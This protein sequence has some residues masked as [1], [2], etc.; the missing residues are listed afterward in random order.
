MDSVFH[1]RQ[2]RRRDETPAG[3]SCLYSLSKKPL[4]F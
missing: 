3:T 4:Y 1:S 2:G